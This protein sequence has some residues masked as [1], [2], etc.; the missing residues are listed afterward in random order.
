[1][2]RIRRPRPEWYEHDS[3]RAL[4]ALERVWV[5]QATRARAGTVRVWMLPDARCAQ[6]EHEPPVVTLSRAK[7][8]WHGA[9]RAEW[10]CLP[11]S[12]ASVAQLVVQ[13]VL[14]DASSASSLLA[15]CARVLSLDGELLLFGLNPAGVAR[16]RLGFSTRR[17]E[18]IRLPGR[19]RAQLG[20]L[21]LVVAAPLGVGGAVVDAVP[22]PRRWLRA[23][24]VL[25]ARKRVAQVI[26]L[27]RA[28][29]RRVRAV[30]QLAPTQIVAESA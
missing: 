25:R 12:D 3:I 16:L 23:A 8:G 5:G 24:Y 7:D 6:D 30:G 29:P 28:V 4:F 1:M 10:D 18:R 15:E 13:H 9:L 21:G 2:A 17:P 11:F 20:R 14:D 27:S 19:L 26:P 22:A